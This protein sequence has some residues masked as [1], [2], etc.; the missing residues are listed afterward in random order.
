MILQRN[1]LQKWRFLV[2]GPHTLTSMKS[3]SFKVPNLPRGCYW[4]LSHHGIDS[5]KT[6]MLAKGPTPMLKRGK[7]RKAK[8]G[9]S[10][11]LRWLNSLFNKY[12]VVVLFKNAPCSLFPVSLLHLVLPTYK[13]SIKGWK[14]VQCSEFYHFGPYKFLCKIVKIWGDVICIDFTKVV[15]PTFLGLYIKI[16]RDQNK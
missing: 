2:A 5:L 7:K 14:A 3:I 1:L 13:T 9:R 6:E 10:F 12:S 16:F 8:G 15:L 4:L 11:G